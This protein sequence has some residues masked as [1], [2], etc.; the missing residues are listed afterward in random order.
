MS[1]VT[2]RSVCLALPLLLSVSLLADDTKPNFTGTWELDAAKSQTLRSGESIQ[3]AIQDAS[4]KIQVKKTTHSPDGKAVT[5]TFDCTVDGTN[6]TYE[7]GGKKAQVSVWYNGPALVVLKTDGPSDDQV[8]Q[9][10][11]QL[12]PDLSTLEME[13]MHITPQDKAETMVFTKKK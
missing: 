4:G 10:K 12:S 7:D 9:S 6:C 2:A 11:L 8:S 1:F 5:S 3:L 13:V